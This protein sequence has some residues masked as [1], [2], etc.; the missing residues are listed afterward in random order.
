[1][2]Y[3]PEVDEV[4]GHNTKTEQH[5]IMKILRMKANHLT[6]P[7]G[8]A[9][10]SLSLSWT[11]G[12]TAAS[13]QKSAR[14]EI[15]NT[16][17]FAALIYDSGTRADIDSL[18]FCPG[19]AL[20]PRTRYF[21]RVTVKANNG[22]SAIGKSFFETGKIGEPW[23]AK[24]ITAPYED[25]DAHFMLRKSFHL[26]KVSN[27]RVYCSALGIYEIEINGKPAAD[28]VLL[29]GYHSYTLEVHAQTFDITHLLQ[30]GENTIG[31]HVGNGWYHSHLGWG[32]SG[33]F[34]QT[35]GAICEVRG[36]VSGK[37]SLIAQ[38]DATWMCAPSPVVK[39]GIYYGEDYDA[40]REIPCWS[41]PSCTQGEW[42]P[43]REFTPALGEAGRLRDRLS[44]PIRIQET[45]SPDVL[46]TPAGE[47]VL[48]F[49]QN[50]TG[51]VEV[52]N[53]DPAGETWSLQVGELLQK[54]NFYRD[55]LRSAEA[56]YTYTSNGA[57][58][59]VRPHF[60]FFGFRY[61]KLTG[62][63]KDLN[64]ADFK[65]HVIHSDLERTGFIETSNPKI[66]RLFQNALWGQKGNFLDV[67]TDCPQRDERLGWTGDAQAFSGT[68]S[69]N[70]DCVAFY[71]KYL[72]DLMLE[73]AA[74]DGGVP[75][76]VPALI[77]W[78]RKHESHSSCAWGDV[79]TVL[80]W[81][82]Y[83][84]AADT[85]LLRRNYIA[86]KEWVRYIKRQDDE[87]GGRGLWIS[88]F[89]FADW[90]ALDNYKDK[91]SSFGGTDPYFIASAYYARSVELTLKA[92]QA[93]GETRDI[94]TYG[95][96]LKKIKSAFVK[97][98]FTPAGKCA[99]DTQTAHVVALHMNLVPENFRKRLT[100]TLVKM[101]K[102]N[103]LALTTGFVGTSV[104]CRVLSDNGHPDIASELLL[105]EKFPSWLYEV[106][107]G[108]TTIWERWNSVLE[109]GTCSGTGMN[110]MNHYAYGAI[111]EWMYRNLSGIRPCDEAPGF[112]KVVI[113]PDAPRA[114]DFVKMKYESPVGEY[115]IEWTLKGGDYQF[116]CTIP[117]NAAAELV[118]PTAP[119]K[120]KMNG[121]TVSSSNL[122]LTSGT[123]TFNYTLAE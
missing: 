115:R 97:E 54:G 111:V 18:S 108:A 60:T 98:Y 123:Y 56:Q 67:P 112:R 62:F 76:T 57:V 72:N 110:S 35:M 2:S 59:K 55:N 40:R 101:I 95:K 91:N 43:A 75:Y 29:P 21:W 104:L 39:S 79:A 11:V 14:V 45:L 64:P 88:G 46:V 44:P 117:F 66:N 84:Y 17:S 10:D 34:G 107:L 50:M 96:L 99:V 48:D 51:W 20:S 33:L 26:D 30:K 120:I 87:N 122:N 86:M 105:R 103:G 90:L 3:S 77:D 12:S 27:A 69:F 23:A 65:A 78:L 53:R 32:N 80:P 58:C 22:D 121:K 113:K 102:D 116:T 38:S 37:D 16:A 15:S 118:L 25:A 94:A 70:M 85:S 63:P 9:L 6:S 5:T 92:A 42:I 82:V 93:L 31:L 100:D 1:M 106:N 109:D 7:V 19:I 74:Y 8:C 68:A 52:T 41:S 36:K 61:V 83:A 114:F 13:K 24:W 89:H 28:E 71:N 4:D 47:T 73:Q 81:T 119:R 49:K